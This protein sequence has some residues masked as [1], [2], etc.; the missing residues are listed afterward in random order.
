MKTED[1]V[2]RLVND[3]DALVQFVEAE[4]D[5]AV[6]ENWKYERQEGDLPHWTV[7]NK[8]RYRGA[9]A[10]EDFGLFFNPDSRYFVVTCGNSDAG[11]FTV[12][13]CIM[14]ARIVHIDAVR[15]FE[16]KDILRII[17]EN[18]EPNKWGL[19]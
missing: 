11:A 2:N 7:A 15:M 14:R 16:L 1:E 5:Q 10:D 9:A 4:L 18:N 13:K 19:T 3:R 6:L 12:G 8:E 17:F